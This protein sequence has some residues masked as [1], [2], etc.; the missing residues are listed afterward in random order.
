MHVC[1][2]LEKSEVSF[3]DSIKRVALQTFAKRTDT[4]SKD[5]DK[6]NVLKK[7]VPMVSHLFHIC[8]PRQD[9]D[10]DKFFKYENQ[11]EPPSLSDKGKL[12]SVKKSD[13]IQ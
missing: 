13:M 12:R 1:E 2:R 6:V 10:L 8:S 5:N 3:T 4:K 9:F 11:R 7:D